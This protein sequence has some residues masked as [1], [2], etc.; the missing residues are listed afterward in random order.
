MNHIAKYIVRRMLGAVDIG[1]T[2]NAY[3]EKLKEEFEQLKRFPDTIKFILKLPD[4]KIPVFLRLLSKAKSQIGQEFY[5][6][7]ELNLKREGFFVEFGATNGV[8]IS[9]TYLLESEFGW[10]G[11]LAEPA[12]CWHEELKRNRKCHIETR[13]V[14]SDSNSTLSFNEV[15]TPDLS[16]INSF[17]ASDLHRKAR[18]VG[19]TYKVKTVSLVDMLDDYNAPKVIDY[20][21]ID[22]EGSEFDILKAFD[23]SKYQF[24]VITCEHNFTPM[25]EKLFDLLTSNGYVRK[26]VDVSNFDDWYI[27]QI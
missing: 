17:S 16:T 9:N 5:V 19:K 27:K 10:S 2:S 7:S 4:E 24:R 20:L 25:R 13:C 11:I 14:W 21:S 1:I 8:D 18:A 3:L 6:L 15:A 26:H 23:F 22:T 12:T